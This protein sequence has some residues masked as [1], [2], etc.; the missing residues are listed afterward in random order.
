MEVSKGLG[1]EDFG[2][3]CILIKRAPPFKTFF[4]MVT[5]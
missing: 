4:L 5:I 2:A 1:E 3:F